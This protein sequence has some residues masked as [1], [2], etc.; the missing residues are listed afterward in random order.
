MC[1]APCL[2]NGPCRGNWPVEGQFSSKPRRSATGWRHEAGQ[3][4]R[5]PSEAEWLHWHDQVN[6]GYSHANEQTPAN[7][8]LAQAASCCPVD[9]F[10]WNSFGDVI[11]NVWQWTETAVDS[12]PGFRI[13]P[14]YDDFSTPTFDSLHNVIK[15]G[16][17][18]STG[19]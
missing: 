12:L 6:P 2:K 9:R 4:L 5:L 18:I 3:S 10:I 11:G 13:H 15:G 14:Y 17:W 19:N 7:I 8:N 1:C 16:S